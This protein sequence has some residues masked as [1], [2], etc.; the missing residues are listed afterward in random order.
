[1]P[2]A[3]ILNYLVDMVLQKSTYKYKE[4]TLLQCFELTTYKESVQANR[5]QW[6]RPP[7]DSLY[8]YVNVKEGIEKNST[9]NLGDKEHFDKEP[10][11]VIKYQFTS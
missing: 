6:T 8:K 4:S 2:R 11:L 1:M 5:L 3:E 7:M 9:V 10:F